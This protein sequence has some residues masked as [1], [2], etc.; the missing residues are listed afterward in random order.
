VKTTDFLKVAVAAWQLRK[1]R[2]VRNLA[3]AHAEGGEQA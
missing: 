3:A 2:W 1:E